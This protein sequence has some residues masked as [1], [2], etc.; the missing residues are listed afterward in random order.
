MKPVVASHRV[1]D[2]VVIE[3]TPLSVG[4]ANV[5][6]GA[7]MEAGGAEEA[8]ESRAKGGGAGPY[9]ERPVEAAR[10]AGVPVIVRVLRRDS[11]TAPRYSPLF[12]RMARARHQMTGG[13]AP[14]LLAAFGL[15]QTV[16]ATVEEYVSGTALAD[17]LGVLR[18]SGA[19]MPVPV[20]LA[21]G[22]GL[23]P[24]W[25][26]AV[27]D[28]IRLSLDSRSVLVDER[29]EVRVLPT[30]GEEQSRHVVGAAL[31]SLHDLVMMSSPEEAMGVEP[32]GRSAMYYLGT[33]L[34]EMLAGVPPVAS[35][36][37][38][39]FEILSELVN[40][41][42][43][44]LRAH[45]ADVHPS[46]SELVHRCLAR[47]P[48]ERFGGW[49]ELVSAFTGIRSLFPPTGPGDV[50]AWIQGVIAHHPTRGEPVLDVPRSWQKL[51]ASGYQAVPLGTLGEVE[52]LPVRRASA[53]A[54]LD[55][56]AVYARADGRPMYAVSEG[57]LIDARPVTRAEIERYFL[58][59]RRAAPTHLGA[60]N[61]ATDDDACTLVPVEVAEAYAAWAGK[62]LATEAEWDAA[63]EKLGAE[64][65]GVGKI[66]EWTAT[67]HEDGGRVIRGGRWRDQLTMPS[68]PAN[69]SFAVS[70]AADLG[71][72]CVAETRGQ[73]AA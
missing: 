41:D 55:P 65:L 44:P 2:N 54:V 32:D 46:V 43:P 71:F 40:R 26:R 9:R 68:Q 25:M 24:V 5:H 34:Y 20:A 15:G 42:A 57:L 52:V 28:E 8:E 39:L 18:G 51:P 50:L 19:K 21:I 27:P 1:G 4:L 67:P 13:P 59:A 33:L 29:G 58:S 14:R 66:W 72:R 12:H 16:L 35:S 63:I 36:D 37:K 38:K 60:L 73:G 10:P 62:R 61:T 23:L 45:R 70:P 48:R 17:V 30:Y 6:R 31:F 11:E 7:W 47:D 64:K 69:R 3:G 56:D 53:L 22:Q 49:G